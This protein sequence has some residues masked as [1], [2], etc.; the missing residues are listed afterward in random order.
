MS[1]FKSNGNSLNTASRTMS[2]M[3][4]GTQ[5]GVSGQDL[6]SQAKGATLASIYQAKK[7]GREETK[8]EVLKQQFQT[9]IERKIGHAQESPSNKI[10]NR[11]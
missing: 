5:G 6:A 3:R 9:E 8:V 2:L 1:E 4:R 11:Y 7:A 10:L